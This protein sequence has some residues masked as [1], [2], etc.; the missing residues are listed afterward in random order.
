MLQSMRTD[1]K[2]LK[3]AGIVLIVLVSVMGF[4]LGFSV[5]QSNKDD[6]RIRRALGRISIYEPVNLERTARGNDGMIE[7]NVLEDYLNAFHKQT[8]RVMEYNGTLRTWNESGG[9]VDTEELKKIRKQNKEAYEILSDMVGN[10]V[11]YVT[12]YTISYGEAY[13]VWTEDW[14]AA[15]DAAGCR[16][17]LEGRLKEIYD[18]NRTI[19]DRLMEE[20]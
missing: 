19:I 5:G 9:K 18:E 10:P 14:A 7:E 3:I 15:L 8:A 1:K 2:Y 12:E 13:E 16:K 4:V 6:I 20:Q 11:K 17:E